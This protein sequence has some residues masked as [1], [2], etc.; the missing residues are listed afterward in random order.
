MRYVL[1]PVSVKLPGF[2]PRTTQTELE[3]CA[4]VGTDGS[5]SARKCRVSA[6]ISDDFGEPL[7]SPTPLSCLPLPGVL[8]HAAVAVLHSLRQT[9]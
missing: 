4:S 8:C 7:G 2:I 3:S 1:V 9:P 5:P 6:L